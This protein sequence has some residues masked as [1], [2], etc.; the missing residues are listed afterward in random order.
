MF[1]L[2]PFQKTFIKQALSPKVDT[3]VL[4]LPRG[5]GKSSLA[6]YLGAR[7]L[8]PGDDLFTPGTESVIIAATL[9]QARICYRV[10]RDILGDNRDYR[11]AD[12]LTRVSI[13]HVPSKTVLLVRSSNAKGALGL[14]NCPVVV[15]DEPGAWAVNEGQAMFDAISTAQGKPGSPLKFILIGTLAPAADGSWWPE[16][17][18]AGSVGTTYVQALQGDSET[19]DKWATIRKCNPLSIFP[20]LRVKLLEERDAARRDTRLKSRFMSYRLNIPTRDESEMLLT[21]DDWA[22]GID[23]EVQPRTGKPIVAV[24]LGGGRSWS[25]AVAI[26]KSGRVEAMAVAPGVARQCTE[27]NVH[28]AL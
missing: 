18:A 24:D 1:E 17:V 16:M 8:T 19:W 6:G 2:R 23:R 21:V 14:L 7:L 22:I 4:C 20:E 5:N 11:L 3:A 13:T 25:A 12:S 26:W 10:A 28:E 15:A 27:W 9:E